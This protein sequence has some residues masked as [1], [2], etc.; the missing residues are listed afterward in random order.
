MGRYA[1]AQSYLEEGL[2]MAHEL[3]GRPRGAAALQLL[4]MSCLGQGFLPTAR[5]HLDMALTLARQFGDKRGLAAANS[6]MAQLHRVEGD[7]ETAAP[8]FNETLAIAR[9]LGDRETEG[10]ALVSLAMVEIERGSEEAARTM[11][12]DAIAITEAIG[13]RRLGRSVV[14]VDDD[15]IEDGAIL[16]VAPHLDVVREGSVRRVGV[17]PYE[18]VRARLGRRELPARHF[19][20]LE[21]HAV[22]SERKPGGRPKGP[23]DRDVPQS[24]GD[25][26]R[27]RGCRD[28]GGGALRHHDGHPALFLL[29]AFVGGARGLG[30]GRLRVVRIPVEN[31]AAGEDCEGNEPIQCAV[32]HLGLPCWIGLGGF[33]DLG[34]ALW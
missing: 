31:G 26:Q 28:A 8:L 30:R 32:F 6:V 12:L 21:V 10:V 27:V 20:A 25:F 13:S 9:E 1:E 15:G 23:D 3:N 5:K 22:R 2:S 4:G 17:F 16:S 33:I 24:A 7:L 18:L 29:E 11:L 19:L 14:V 34:A